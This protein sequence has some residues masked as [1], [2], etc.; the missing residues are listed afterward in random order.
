MQRPLLA[1]LL[2]LLLLTGA[3]KIQHHLLTP[4]LSNDAPLPSLETEQRLVFLLQYLASDYDRA[5]A[6][7]EIRDTL[8]YREME[9]FAGQIVA[10]YEAAPN[11]QEFTSQQLRALQNA[12][13]QKAPLSDI[14]KTCAVAVANVVKEKGLF[15][16]PQIAPD[17]ADGETLFKEN[18]VTCHGER[19]DG[20][21]TAADTLNPKPRDFTAPERLNVCT[22]LQF[23]QA[24]TFGVEGTAMASFAEAFTPEQ[25]W[26]LAFYLMTL[27]RDF[28][29][30]AATGIALLPLRQLATK[31]NFELAELFSYQQ[32][33]QQPDTLWQPHRYVDY[34]RQNP[35]DL[36]M[37]ESLTLVERKLQQSFTAF[38][39]GDSAA[40]IQLAEEA[41][42]LGF[43]PIERKLLSRTYLRFERTHTEY[44]WC[45]EEKGTP[46]RARALVRDLLAI[47]QD[48][49]AR[50]GLRDLKNN[51]A[52]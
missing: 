40:A 26:N 7:G 9:R 2:F 43:E 45:I 8:E 49:R 5:V 20:T 27:R 30:L 6:N 38:V 22:P 48:I 52:Q 21:G 10:L 25:R 46:E 3:T 42:W 24:L 18:C 17:L 4:D 33:R 15:L 34:Y 23:Y 35:P 32:R 16:F 13:A 14:R 44:H 19:G 37:D 12:V 31:N 51:T 1:Y 39:R 28:K 11:Q 36:A 41:Y 29:P 50:R 47:V